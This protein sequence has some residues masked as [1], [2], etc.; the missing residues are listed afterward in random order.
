[1]NREK[2]ELRHRLPLTSLLGQEFWMGR[3]TLAS[4]YDFV[5]VSGGSKPGNRKVTWTNSALDMGI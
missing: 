2:T 1:M 4:Q 5:T 3:S